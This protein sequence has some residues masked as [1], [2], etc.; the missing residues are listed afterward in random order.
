[1][2]TTTKIKIIANDI[3][4]T[5]NTKQKLPERKDYNMRTCAWILANFILNPKSEIHARKVKT[6]GTYDGEFTHDKLNR[7]TYTSLANQLVKYIKKNGKMPPS[8]KYGEKKIQMKVFIYGFASVVK[9]YFDHKEFP[10]KQWFSRTSFNKP[11]PKPTF[12]KYG[13]ATSHGC[14]NMGQNNSVYCAPHSMQECIRNLTGQVISQSTLASWA[15]TSSGG[16]G[17]GGIET[18]IAMA[19]KKLDVKFSCR[20]YNFSELGW[21]GIRNII[22]SDNQDCII[23]NLYRYIPGVQDGEGH[24]ETINEVYDDY[25]DVQNSLGSYC[26]DGCYCGYVE[27]RYLS[28]FE[29]YMSGISQKS[30]LVIT[31]E[32]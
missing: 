22:N 2:V 16:T 25:C 26:D 4:N 5:V 29:T 24:Y 10:A 27:E 17:H 6:A 32:G 18:A 30:V 31:R 11:K 9:Y 3:V 8:L 7:N 13:H 14:D 19:A 1:M 21:N 12:K 15:G 23:H 20:W 28:T